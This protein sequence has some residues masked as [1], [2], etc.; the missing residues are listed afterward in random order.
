MNFVNRYTPNIKKIFVCMCA[1]MYIYIYIYIY[2]SRQFK[3]K[4]IGS[5]LKKFEN[6]WSN[7]QRSSSIATFK[8]CDIILKAPERN[9]VSVLERSE[10]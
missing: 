4:K 6:H 3:K 5:L 9:L 10:F 7:L 1:C 8:T 2:G